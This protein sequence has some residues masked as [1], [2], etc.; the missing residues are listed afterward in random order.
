MRTEVMEAHRVPMRPDSDNGFG[1]FARTVEHES[2]EPCRHGEPC[3]ELQTDEQF[4]KLKKFEP[5]ER[6]RDDLN[7]HEMLE[8]NTLR[9]WRVYQLAR[10]AH[11]SDSVTV[12]LPRHPKPVQLGEAE[13]GKVLRS[14]GLWMR[15]SS[16]KVA[17]QIE[18][19]FGRTWTKGG[20]SGRGGRGVVDEAELA[21]VMKELGL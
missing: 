9:Q 12:G 1:G 16:G 21:R 4:R 13:N 3:K 8:K 6:V 18:Y 5:G 19:G 20:T 15:S 17:R 10:G 11:P 7:V 14:S 2:T